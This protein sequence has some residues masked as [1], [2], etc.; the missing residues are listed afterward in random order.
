MVKRRL[1]IAKDPSMTTFLYVVFL[2]LPKSMAV[3]GSSAIRQFLNYKQPWWKIKASS[4]YENSCLLLYLFV[5]DPAA[6][7]SAGL[8]RKPLADR[9]GEAS[10]DLFIPPSTDWIALG[11]NLWGCTHLKRVDSCFSYSLSLCDRVWLVCIEILW[12]DLWY[13]WNSGFRREERILMNLMRALS[14]RKYRWDR[15]EDLRS[16]TN[17][18]D[19]VMVVRDELIGK[20]DSF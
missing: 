12:C 7:V 9:S 19:Q 5:L 8:R 4:N 16:R 6:D 18:R 2:D 15:R 11:F 20:N 13:E 14:S 1:D 17:R 10:E 3:F